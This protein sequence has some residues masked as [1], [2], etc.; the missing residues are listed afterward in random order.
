MEY[1]V[2]I[3]LGNR[4]GFNQ[5]RISQCSNPQYNGKIYVNNEQLGQLDAV[6]VRFTPEDQFCYMIQVK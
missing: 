3:N 1:A 4:N 2:G 5:I 6:C